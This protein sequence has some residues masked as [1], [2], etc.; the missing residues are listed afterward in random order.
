MGLPQ[1][2]LLLV[3]LIVPFRE[4]VLSGSKN[5]LFQ[6]P[7]APPSPNPNTHTQFYSNIC[8]VAFLST[9]DASFSLQHNFQNP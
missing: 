3:T 8:A 7:H 4:N 2:V 6:K 9:Y 5:L 1:W